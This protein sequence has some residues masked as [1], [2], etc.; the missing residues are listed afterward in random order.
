MSCL[1]FWRVARPRSELCSRQTP[2]AAPSPRTGHV[3]VCGRARKEA[4]AR[5]QLGLVSRHNCLSVSWASLLAPGTP[6]DSGTEWGQR[7]LP[8]R[9]EEG[10]PATQCHPYP[11]HWPQ[12]H[13][14]Q[15]RG[16]RTAPGPHTHCRPPHT[17][18]SPPPPLPRVQRGPPCPPIWVSP[19]RGPHLLVHSW[20]VASRPPSH[21]ATRNVDPAARPRRAPWV[22]CPACP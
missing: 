11:C 19:G 18:T 3:G 2:A 7:S 5:K 10:D 1:S 17:L 22:P 16:P 15:P 4:C 12:H 8:C 9:P 6:G 14:G 13:H 21:T 20:G